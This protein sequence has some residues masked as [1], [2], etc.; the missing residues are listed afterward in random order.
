MASSDKVNTSLSMIKKNVSLKPF[1]TL[2]IEATAHTFLEISNKNQLEELTNSNFFTRNNPVILGGGSNVLIKQNPSNPVLKITIAGIEVVKEDDHYVWVEAGAGVIWHDLVTYAVENE[3]GGIENLALIPGTVGA[4]PIQNI[5]AYG[6]EL[7]QV[8]ESLEY[9]DMQDQA[10]KVA[11][12]E[13]CKFGYRDSI[14]KNE[15]KNCVIILSVTIKL[16]KPPHKIVTDYYALQ[17]WFER[18]KISSRSIEDVYNTVVSIRRSKLPDPELIGNAGSFFKNPVVNQ[19]TYNEIRRAFPDVPSFQTE[20]EMVKIP[21][22]WLIEKAGWKAKR[23][24]KVGTYK[25]QALV[26]VNHGGATG[27]EIFEHALRIKKSVF[28]MF[29]LELTPEVNI[30]E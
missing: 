1:N 4:A 19:S 25:N 11:D 5:G 30:I 12:Y 9:F 20:N 22:G 23:V 17:E 16:K 28:E 10:I 13:M 7:E 15:L 26:I 2:G 3:Y 24:S 6:V 8:F 18:N 14:F 27:L 21:A 29:G